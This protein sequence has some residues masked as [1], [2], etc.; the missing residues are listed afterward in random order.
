MKKIKDAKWHKAVLQTK[1]I[2]EALKKEISNPD[3]IKIIDKVSNLDF[4][5]KWGLI[6]NR[7]MPLIRGKELSGRQIERLIE[8]ALSNTW[9]EDLRKAN[10]FFKEFPYNSTWDQGLI[11]MAASEMTQQEWQQ[12][13]DNV[14]P[15]VDDISNTYRVTNFIRTAKCVD[16]KQ[17]E[18]AVIEAKNLE[19]KIDAVTYNKDITLLI[20]LYLTI[21]DPS[22]VNSASERVGSL[23]KNQTRVNVEGYKKLIESVCNVDNENWKDIFSKVSP[24][25]GFIN[26]NTWGFIRLIETIKEK[27]PPAQ[28][29]WKDV[30]AKANQLKK[31]HMTDEQDLIPLIEVAY[32][33]D[34]LT[35]LDM[36]AR[37]I[38]SL[39]DQNIT[40]SGYALFIEAVKGLKNQAWEFTKERVVPLLNKSL[41]NNRGRVFFRLVQTSNLLTTNEQW[42]HFKDTFEKSAAERNDLLH[43]NNHRSKRQHEHWQNQ[44]GHHGGHG[45]KGGANLDIH[46]T[47]LSSA[48]SWL[49]DERWSKLIKDNFATNGGSA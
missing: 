48:I 10:L 42:G 40:G 47:K 32:K 30:V 41:Q 49:S 33:L 25:S 31:P 5:E 45:P 35:L 26:K 4:D 22:K 36:C 39:I 14:K 28:L 7:I 34:D 27:M 20:E 16:N 8:A 3:K 19:K 21:K 15:Y 38:D 18:D 9:D 2:L 23:L 37:R 17:W 24:Y 44:G 13:V 29:L 46:L 12:A 1:S 11:I 43:Q 6:V